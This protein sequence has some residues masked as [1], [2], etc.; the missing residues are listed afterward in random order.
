MNI[1]G[2]ISS[3]QFRDVVLASWRLGRTERD[4]RAAD[5]VREIKRRLL[6]ELQANAQAGPTADDSGVDGSAAPGGALAAD[7]RFG[8]GGG[9]RADGGQKAN[10]G[11]ATEDAFFEDR[12]LPADGDPAVFGAEAAGRRTR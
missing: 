2:K 1:A 6:A 10:G 12:G 3:A 11:H 8:S 7:G 4:L 9:H 5:M